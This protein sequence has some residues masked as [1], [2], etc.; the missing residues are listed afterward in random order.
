[1]TKN[2]PVVHCVFTDTEKNLQEL[3]EESF[4]LYLHRI[5]FGETDDTVQCP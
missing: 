5:L 2:T 4:R 1:M 3:L